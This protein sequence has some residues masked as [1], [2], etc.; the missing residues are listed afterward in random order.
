MVT[1]QLLFCVFNCIINTTEPLSALAAFPRS[2]K[3]QSK[4]LL[5]TTEN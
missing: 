5:P 2:P 1:Q 4:L 3:F